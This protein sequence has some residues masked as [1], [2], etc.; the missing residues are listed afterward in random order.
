[1]SIEI[2]QI[3]GTTVSGFS[4]TGCRNHGLYAI[5]QCNEVSKISLTFVEKAMKKGCQKMPM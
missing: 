4:D 3:I 2:P 5:V 1:M